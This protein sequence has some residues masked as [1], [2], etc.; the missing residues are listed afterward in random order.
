MQNENFSEK[1]LEQTPVVM[2]QGS[3]EFTSRSDDHSTVLAFTGLS[4]VVRRLVKPGGLRL[5]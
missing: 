4:R 3:G 5:G 2:T 1:R